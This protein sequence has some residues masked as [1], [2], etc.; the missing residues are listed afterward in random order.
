[1]KHE[2]NPRNLVLTV[3]S[4]E[5]IYLMTGLSLLIRTCEKEGYYPSPQVIKLLD[6]MIS[7]ESHMIF[8]HNNRDKKGTL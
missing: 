6:D 8:G 7:A 1:M 3:D 4:V 2:V 5:F